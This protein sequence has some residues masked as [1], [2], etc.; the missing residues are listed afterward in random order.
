[1]VAF[2]Q[3]A[4]SRI[5]EEMDSVK[6]EITWAP[7]DVPADHPWTGWFEMQN[8]PILIVERLVRTIRHEHQKPQMLALE[9]AYS[10][11]RAPRDRTCMNVIV[12]SWEVSSLENGTTVGERGISEMFSLYY[13]RD[14]GGVMGGVGVEYDLLDGYV[15]LSGLI[16]VR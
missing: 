16:V 13:G 9:G 6:L 2:A 14:H 1:M 8:I 10:C 15:F 12:T 5:D 4:R 7:V 3:S 11:C